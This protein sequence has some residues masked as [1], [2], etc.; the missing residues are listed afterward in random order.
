MT[1]IS[2]GLTRRNVLQTGM[3]GIIGTGVAPLVFSKGAWAQ[4]FCNNPTGDTVTLGLNLPLT[5]TY[6][7]EGADEQK[8]YEL[9]IAHLNGE[10]DVVLIAVLAPTE[11]KGNGILVKKVGYVSLDT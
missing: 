11:L 2:R 7:E 3:A 10:G 8:A 6:A 1:K 5:G 4:E 9:A